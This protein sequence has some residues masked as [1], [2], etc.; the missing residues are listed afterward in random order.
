MFLNLGVPRRSGAVGM[1][2][3]SSA[4]LV[5]GLAI[6]CCAVGCAGIAAAEES[7]VQF[8]DPGPEHAFS[9]EVPSGWTVHGGLFRLGYSDVRFV[10]D[11]RSSDG[12]TNV[13]MSDVTIGPYALPTTFHPR[14]GEVVD[15]GM[16]AQPTVSKYST[17][18]EYAPKYAQ[19]RF[20]DVCRSL[21][22]ESGA[23]VVDVPD[24]LPEDPAA[25]RSTTG[26]VTYRC[27]ADSA[28]MVAFAFVK[29]T[30]GDGVWQAR[31]LA[32][33][34]APV[35]DA[36]TARSVLLHCVRSF[37]LNPQ[38]LGYQA[39]ME[40]QGL[41]Y[42]RERQQG[43]MRAVQQEVA[44]AEAKMKA[45]QGQVAAFERGQERSAAQSAAWG[46]LLTGITPTVDPMGNTR[47][48]WTGTHSRYWTNG[49]GDTVN[50]DVAPP[51]GGWQEL[52]VPAQ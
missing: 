18:E 51:G 32:S 5:L 15:L 34:V 9:V 30:L 8:D 13:R 35:D 44:Q 39:R 3:R 50:A 27:A 14:E 31:T 26:Q 22:P 45:L 17:G 36:A 46:N 28:A 38:W 47:E 1:R 48:V 21:Q 43:R 20:K 49:R 42:Q 25:K 7:W 10:I 12:R 11:L 29:T 41:Q 52:R 4:A 40:A 19:A 16:Q 24:Y 6:A 23:P 33:F 2:C 37:R